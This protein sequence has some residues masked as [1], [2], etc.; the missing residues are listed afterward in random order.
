[1]PVI[2]RLKTW[3]AHFA[4]VRDGTKRFELRRDDRPFDVG[5][6]LLLEEWEPAKGG[7][8]TGHVLSVRVRYIL[9][10]A[11]AD[12]PGLAP[13]YCILSISEPFQRS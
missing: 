11:T 8:Y 3:P 2:H 4:A 12:V 6:C 10:E 7:G 1:M 9:R 13:G 5:H